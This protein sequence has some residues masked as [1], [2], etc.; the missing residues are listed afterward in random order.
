MNGERG[1]AADAMNALLRWNGLKG[2]CP[3]NEADLVE[4]LTEVNDQL[5]ERVNTSLDEAAGIKRDADPVLM[6]VAAAAAAAGRAQGI[7][8]SWNRKNPAVRE[9][10]KLVTAKNVSR[11]QLGFK[12][13]IDNSASK[14]FLPRLTEKPH[15]KKPLSILREYDEDGFEH[16]SHP[17]A[18]ELDL[19]EPS[20]EYLGAEGTAAEALGLAEA[21]LVLV[22]RP[23]QLKK[24]V[25]A[26]KKES[27]IAVDLEHHWYRSF[28]GFTSLIQISTG[29]TDFIVDPF[30]LFRELTLLNEVFADPNIIKVRSSLLCTDFLN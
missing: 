17:Y 2:R 21:E 10:V 3:D 23:E 30:P 5:M 24:M 20:D 6:E 28:Q 27:R 26:L 22:E 9:E 7:S 13:L 16:C 11:P 18:Y 15:A 12:D 25:Q 1:R 4:M 14:P 8:G 19:F 29:S